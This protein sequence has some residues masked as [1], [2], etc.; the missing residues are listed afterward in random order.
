MLRLGLPPFGS[1]AP[2]DTD[3]AA[4]RLGF[5]EASGLPAPMLMVSMVGFGSLCHE[6]GFSL[7]KA[8]VSTATIWALPGQIAYVEMLSAGSPVFALLFAVALANARFLPMVATFMPYIRHGMPGRAAPYWLAHFVTANSWIFVIRRSPDLASERR[9][10]YFL[11]FAISCLVLG[12]AGTAL[13]FVLA[14]L[15]PKTVNHGLLFLNPIY[16]MLL[17]LETPARSALLAVGF[18]AIAGPLLA[19]LSADWGLLAAGLICGTLGFA[20]DRAIREARRV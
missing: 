19:S 1:A 5:L 17:F 12:F 16:F 20:L 13:G 18:G 14:G 11:G 7:V 10:A 2:L 8:L 15:V 4:F 6:T 9:W 3:R